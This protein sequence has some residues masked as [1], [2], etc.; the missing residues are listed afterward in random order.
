[1]IDLKGKNVQLCGRVSD[2]PRDRAESEFGC[3]ESWCMAA[4]AKFVFNPC[5]IVDKA[6][7]HETAMRMCLSWLV[8]HADVLV[9]LPGYEMSQGAWVE[10]K[11]ADACGIKSVQ[12]IDL[13]AEEGS[14]GHA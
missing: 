7:S 11:V 14:Y 4:G 13:M 3:A 12:L 5:A 8:N 1:M 2:L 6:A 10:C 9:K